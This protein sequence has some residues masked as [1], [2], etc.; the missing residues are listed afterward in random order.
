MIIAV[1]SPSQSMLLEGRGSHGD[2]SMTERNQ[3][4]SLVDGE[5]GVEGRPSGKDHSKKLWLFGHMHLS[6]L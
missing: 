2:S 4:A 3:K 1:S 6:H 5:G